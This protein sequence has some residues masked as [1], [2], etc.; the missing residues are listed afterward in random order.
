MRQYKLVRLL[1]LLGVLAVMLATAVVV[2]QPAPQPTVGFGFQL[3]P[4]T[5]GPFQLTKVGLW[6]KLADMLPYWRKA[7]GTDIPLWQGGPTGP[8]GA[9]GATGGIGPTGVTGATGGIGATGATG[10][11]GGVG[12][13]GITGATGGIGLT[14]STGP[15]GITGATGG[16]GATG[17]TGATG[18]IGP[19]GPTGITGGVGPTGPTGPTGTTGSTGPT[20]AAGS[21]AGLLLYFDHPQNVDT[22]P[23]STATFTFHA[24]AGPTAAF[25]TRPSGSFL[26]D[27]WMALQKF[28]ISG[29]GGANDGQIPEICTV[30]ALTLTMCFDT[31]FTLTN[32]THS[33]T[34]TID[35]EGLST[36]PATGTVVTESIT[37]VTNNAVNSNGIPLDNYVTAIGYPGQTTIPAGTWTF[38]GWFSGD[39]ASMQAFFS[40]DTRDSTGLITTH[41]FNTITTGALSASLT[42]YTITYTQQNPITIAT[43]DRLVVRVLG[44]NTAGGAHSVTWQYQGTNASYVITTFAVLAQPGPQGPTGPTGYTGPTGNIGPTGVTGAA[45]TIPGPTGATGGIGP[46][47]LTGPTGV[48]S[49]GPTGKTGPTGLQGVTGP[50]GGPVGPTGYTGP[51]GPT[52]LMGINRS[53][54]FL[55]TTPGWAIPTVNGTR[56]TTLC[57]NACAAGGSGGSGGASTSGPG[58]GGGE[59]TEGNCFALNP[60]DVTL[61]VTA[62]AAALGVSGADGQDGAPSAVI[63]DQT[64]TLYLYLHAGFGGAAYA[65][66][67]GSGGGALGA[68]TSPSDIGHAGLCMASICGGSSGGSSGSPGMPGGNCRQGYG[69][70]PNGPSFGAGGGAAGPGFGGIDGSGGN[71]M[72]GSGGNA[73]ANSC[74][75]GGGGANGYPGG[76]SGSGYVMLNWIGY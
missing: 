51:T 40:V 44:I 61:S 8:T 5:V 52:G 71:G 4:Q 28:V 65:F 2:A 10:A 9:T 43:G 49:T 70:I 1:I 33:G 57:A 17:A 59:W 42:Q 72:D 30:A 18:G 22:V 73:A 63:G 36:L 26:S 75:G 37:G 15:T 19:T 67:A 62:G 7:D 29:T 45:S 55:V 69:G 35:N 14:G 31:D 39:N 32:V 54:V 74:A 76:T 11:T 56:I 48:G 25:I 50:S 3:T 68:T 13:T 20:G 46:T 38:V 47:G 34:L 60:T 23:T 21:N 24:A 12:P 53:Q 41:Q 64:G 16:I 66:G 27:G 58:G 6:S